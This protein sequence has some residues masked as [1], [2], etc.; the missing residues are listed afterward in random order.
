[1]TESEVLGQLSWL[2]NELAQRASVKLGLDQR[3]VLVR[4][5]VVPS[6][7]LATLI[8]IVTELMGPPVKPAGETARWKNWFD[9]FF[10]SVGGCEK[11]QSLWAR[12]IE[13]RVTLYL[14][15]WPWASEPTRTSVRAGIACW[16]EAR[17]FKLEDFLKR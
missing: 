1:M 14:A 5:T 2:V 6:D 4:S 8:P 11:Q 16:D 7:R 3:S 15:F 17:R 13:D 12:P 9:P 10:K